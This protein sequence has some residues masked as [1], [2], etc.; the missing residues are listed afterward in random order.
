MGSSIV[1]KE[2]FTQT[3]EVGLRREKE[4]ERGLGDVVAIT[5]ERKNEE[6]SGC[7]AILRGEEWREGNSMDDNKGD[8]TTG[9]IDGKKNALEKTVFAGAK[10]EATG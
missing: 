9:R 6:E 4:R 8:K 3:K 2:K 5:T 1:C 10:R 7:E